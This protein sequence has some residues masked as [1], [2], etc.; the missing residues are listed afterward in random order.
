MGALISYTSFAVVVTIRIVLNDHPIATAAREY[1]FPGKY[2][3]SVGIQNTISR[4]VGHRHHP[5]LV[6]LLTDLSSPT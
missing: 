5:Q 6:R 1:A 3:S 4:T 2:S